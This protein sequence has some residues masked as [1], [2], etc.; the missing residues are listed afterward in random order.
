MLLAN[1]D[2]TF[3]P[4]VDYPVGIAPELLVTADF[5]GDGKPDIA[6][7]NVC[8]SDSGCLQG[9]PST[10]SVLLGIG[11]GTFQPRVDYGTGTVLWGLIT[12][13]FNGDGKAD[14]AT[15]QCSYGCT[16]TFVT[17]WLGNGDGTFQ[18]PLDVSVGTEPTAMAAGEFNGDGILDLAVTDDSGT[19]GVL[20]GYGSGNFQSQVS[21]AAGKYPLGVSV[22][23][24]NNDGKMDLAI[25][26]ECGDPA[27]AYGAGAISLLPGKGNGTFG[28]ALEYQ[29]PFNPEFLTLVDLNGDGNLDIAAS[30]AGGET[31]LL[32]DGHGHLGSHVD[33]AGSYPL[34]VAIGDVNG[35]GILDMAVANVLDSNVAVMYGY[36]DGS[37]EG[38]RNY[39]VGTAAALVATG[40]F[41]GDGNPDLAVTLQQYA[42]YGAVSILLGNGQGNFGS[43][44]LATAGQFPVGIAAADF[45]GDGRLDLA[46]SNF[47]PVY[48]DGSISILLGNGDGTFGSPTNL[49]P[50]GYYP[51]FIVVGDFNRDS[52]LDFAVTNQQGGLNGLG[53][54]TV[55]IGNGDGTFHGPV[56]YT[57]QNTPDGLVEADFNNDGKLDLAVANARS[58]TVSVLLGNGDGTFQ[59][60]LD[61]Q[62]NFTAYILAKGDFNHDGNVD[63]AIPNYNNTIT[64]LLGNGNGTFQEASQSPGVPQPGWVVVG[65]FNRD[66]NP[67]LLVGAVANTG[68]E[69]GGTYLLSG[70]GNGTFQS[71]TQY[72]TGTGNGYMQLVDVNSDGSPEAVISNGYENNVTVL[73]N[74]RGTRVHTKSSQNPSL[75]GEQVTF[76]TTVVTSLRGART[77]PTGRAT[78][79]DGKTLLGV[80]G[81][82]NG[83]ASYTTSTLSVGSHKIKARYSGDANF[84]RNEAQPILQKVTQ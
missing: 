61:Y 64:I 4:P 25:A 44:K 18:G 50:N 60:H 6:A 62:L 17:I 16:P 73:L 39:Q 20:L 24:F 70:N 80:V 34:N 22:G 31:V 35:D 1:G 67:D 30:A 53:N 41:N 5:N 49:Y 33:Y 7:L 46:V 66:G 13:D 71:A 9:T 54:V 77:M 51:T 63:L 10:F 40:D 59:P 72:Q 29:A 48:T 36:G 38:L 2:G 12:A 56:S 55:F 14:L 58:T 83:Q 84:S 8:G 57:T 81:L 45:N 19:V 75:F 69:L 74:L 15:I 68:G 65:D 52:K 42:I 11:D 27:C 28:T 37:F 82:S 47:G 43:T 3:Q 76:T 79:K 21:Y 32:G 26:D 78:F 23:D